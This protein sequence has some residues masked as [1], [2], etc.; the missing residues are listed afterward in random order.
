MDAWQEPSTNKSPQRGGI[1]QPTFLPSPH[2][3]TDGLHQH[4]GVEIKCQQ[5]LGGS[6]LSPPLVAPGVLGCGPVTPVSSLL[7]HG[8]SP[9]LHHSSLFKPVWIT[10]I[11]SR[12]LTN[13]IYEHPFPH[14]VT[15][16][17]PRGWNLM[18]LG[19]TVQPTAS[20]WS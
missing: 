15:L 10:R 4:Y 18:S 20:P 5:V 2:C 16:T 12:S 14:E 1:K 9:C 7:S 13:H 19:D 3:R 8:L 17:G 11:I 6:F